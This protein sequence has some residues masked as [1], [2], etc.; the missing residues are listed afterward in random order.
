MGGAFSS[1]QPKSFDV[2]SEGRLNICQSF[3]V[4]VSLSDYHSFNA[5]RVSDITIRM[6]FDD[7][8]DVLHFHTLV[9][10]FEMERFA[11]AY[12]MGSCRAILS[13]PRSTVA[14]TFSP[15]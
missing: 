11:I 6:S 14:F 1:I 7:Y 12:C 15:D 4:G 5:D 13:V 9:E 8:F 2:K 3:G 10:M